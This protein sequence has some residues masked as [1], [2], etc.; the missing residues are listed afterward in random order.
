[1]KK[2]TNMFLFELTLNL[3]KFNVNLKIQFLKSFI[4]LFSLHKICLF[5]VEVFFFPN[6]IKKKIF[7]Y[8]SNVVK[9][10]II[11]KKIATFG[12]RSVV[13]LQTYSNPSILLLFIYYI[14]F[15]FD[16]KNLSKQYVLNVVAPFNQHKLAITRNIN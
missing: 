6:L 10:I 8:F 15:K 11:H 7:I 16:Q 2:S 14:I 3:C 5:L 12:Y 9:M 13:Q 4:N 1:M